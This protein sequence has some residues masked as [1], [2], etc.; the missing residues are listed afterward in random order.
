VIES[1][2]R[3]VLDALPE[4]VIG[5]AKGETRW[6]GMTALCGRKYFNVIASGAKQSI[7]PRAETWI[8]SLRSR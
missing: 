2:S 6:R 5:L 1:I 7:Y 8:A 3:S 4:P